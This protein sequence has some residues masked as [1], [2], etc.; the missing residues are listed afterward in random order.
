MIR[1]MNKGDIKRIVDIWLS[2]SILA[3]DFIEYS[4]WHNKVGKLLQ[5]LSNSIV[6]VCIDNQNFIIGFLAL[7]KRSR[8]EG[9]IA[10]LFI[11]PRFQGKGFGSEL[12]NNTKDLY[13]SLSIHVYQKN[14]D[15]V[16]FY[17]QHKFRELK[18][19][20]EKETDQPKIKMIW[21]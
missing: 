15:A 5:E 1:E 18:Q 14:E 11:D 16:K 4:F 7:Q 17:K 19:K 2:A 12:L 8:N 20:I 13:Q 6:Y 3:H 21:P 9:Y 10:E